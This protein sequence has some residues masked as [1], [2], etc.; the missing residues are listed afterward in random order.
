MTDIQDNNDNSQ[1]FPLVAHLGTRVL[2]CTA[3]IRFL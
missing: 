1:V 3:V 2:V